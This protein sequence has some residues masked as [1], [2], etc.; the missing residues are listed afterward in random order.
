MVVFMALYFFDVS[1]SKLG[2]MINSFNLFD[3][4]FAFMV[5]KDGTIISHPDTKLNGEKASS[6]L[7]NLPFDTTSTQSL[8]LNNKEHIIVFSRGRRLLTG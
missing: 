4:G 5:S 8:D 3:A 7:G 2:N 1:L 6:F